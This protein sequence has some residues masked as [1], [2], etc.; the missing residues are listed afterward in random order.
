MTPHTDSGRSS[1]VR[2]SLTHP[3]RIDELAAGTA[4][5]RIGITFCSG[6]SGPSAQAHVW[7][8]DLEADL[9]AIVAW[10]AGSVVTLI[11]AHEFRMLQVPML[12][13]A[14]AARGLVW[15]HLPIVDLQAPDAR[16]ETAWR[17]AGRTVRDSLAAG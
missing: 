2:T 14:V 13:A 15:L 7:Q 3:L 4:G 10:G 5:G 11:E 17:T 12:D 9:D 1:R 8:R 16:F 6:K